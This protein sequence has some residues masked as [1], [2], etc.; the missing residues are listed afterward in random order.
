M[1]FSKRMTEDLHLR[2]LS[3]TN[4]EDVRPGSAQAFRNT[5]I[6][7]PTGH[8]RRASPVIS[9]ISRMSIEILPYRQHHRSLW[10]SSFFFEHT[11]RA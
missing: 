5:A 8:G 11:L 1:E 3:E 6:N 4:A 7:L 2:G 10:Q 9:S